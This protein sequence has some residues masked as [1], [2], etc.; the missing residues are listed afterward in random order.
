M[1]KGRILTEGVRKGLLKF[2]VFGIKDNQYEVFC[3]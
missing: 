3:M 1:K 2:K